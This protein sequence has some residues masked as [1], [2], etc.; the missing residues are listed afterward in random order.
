MEP[1]DLS[2]LNR[3]LTAITR[4]LL[5]HCNALAECPICNKIVKI[6]IQG[7][8][9]TIGCSHLKGLPVKVNVTL[10]DLEDIDSIESFSISTKPT[11]ED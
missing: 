8:K 7:S 10:E 4:R 2:S 5:S 9:V 6:R 3:E 1:T 11:K